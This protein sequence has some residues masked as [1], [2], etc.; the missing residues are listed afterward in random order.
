[1]PPK[2]KSLSVPDVMRSRVQEI[3]TMTDALCKDM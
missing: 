3:S 2:P 1:M